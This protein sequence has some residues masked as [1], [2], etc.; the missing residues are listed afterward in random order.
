LFPT[1]ARVYLT[2]KDREARDNV[3]E[4][5]KIMNGFLEKRR[6]AMEKPDYTD[7]GDLLSI[8]LSDDQFKNDNQMIIDECLTFFFAGSQTSA[9][10]ITN[11]IC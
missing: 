4:I 8:L 5:R 1:S 2:Q 11:M 10:T 7:K 9:I 6:I 3:Y